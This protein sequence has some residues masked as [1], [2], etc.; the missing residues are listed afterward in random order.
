M[1]K[2]TFHVEHTGKSPVF[3]DVLTRRFEGWTHLV[4]LGCWHSVKEYSQLYIV[5]FS[6]YPGFRI[7]L[8]YCAS[9]LKRELSQQDI[10][11]TIENVEV[12]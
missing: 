1:I 11:V 10:L 8:R 9:V 4:G 2:A 12:L 3:E 7:D 6:D 5:I